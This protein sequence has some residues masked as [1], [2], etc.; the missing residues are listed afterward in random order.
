MQ[1]Q[2]QPQQQQ[3]QEK[4]KEKEEKEVRKEGAVRKAGTKGPHATLL[5]FCG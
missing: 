1:P 5:V 3:Q 4:K 2:P